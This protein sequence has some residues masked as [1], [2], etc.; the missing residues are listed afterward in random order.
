MVK[1]RPVIV[2]YRH[3][4]NSKLVSVVPIS[5]T[6]PYPIKEF[7]VETRDG[8]RQLYLDNKKS[9]VKC[10]I[11]NTVSLERLHLIRNKSDGTRSSPNVG[12][13]FLIK[14]KEAIRKEYRL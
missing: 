14:I 11:L 6:K 9:W 10:D 8:F 5:T 1:K 7:H 13:D 2:V 4:Y 12:A 3:R